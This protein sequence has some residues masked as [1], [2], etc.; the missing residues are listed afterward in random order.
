MKIQLLGLFA[1]LGF[2]LTSPV[3]ADDLVGVWQ[4]ID[5]KTGSPKAL[6]EISKTPKGTYIG[7]VVKV[8][9]RVGYVPQEKCIKCPA[10]YTNQPILGLEVFNGLKE[11]REHVYSDGQI[12]DPL[13]G[14]LYSLKGKL[15]TNKKRL[16]L[17]GYIG[18]SAIGR[19][20][21]WIRQ[22]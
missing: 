5:D 3:W 17:R 21:T 19:T 6:I 8:T 22:D 12:L 4:N 10:P 11:I 14:G 7:K 1:C 16:H 15:T 18:V 2:G 9:P 20:Q 13:T